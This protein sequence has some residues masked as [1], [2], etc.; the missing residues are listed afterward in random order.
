MGIFEKHQRRVRTGERLDLS[1]QRSEGIMPVLLWRQ[2]SPGIASVI[3]KTEYLGE[4]PYV[5]TR[6]FGLSEESV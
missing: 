2:F 5:L 1:H 6:C 4:Q 3:A